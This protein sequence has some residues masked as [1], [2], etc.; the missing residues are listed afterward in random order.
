MKA[1]TTH[2]LRRASLAVVFGSL[3][4]VPSFG[5]DIKNIVQGPGIAVVQSSG[6]VTVSIPTGGITLTMLSSGTIAAVRG[7][8]GPAGSTGPQG[9]QGLTGAGGVTGTQ[10]L[11]GDIGPVGPIGAIGPV[12]PAGPTGFTGLQGPAGAEGP[13]GPIGPE[14][15]IGPTGLTGINGLDGPTGPTGATGPIGATGGLGA[16]GALGAFGPKGPFGPTGPTGQKG[17]AGVTGDAGPTGATGSTG[18]MGSAG[19]IGAAGAQ[20][21]SV[22]VERVFS[23]SDLTFSNVNMTFE[24][25]TVSFTSFTPVLIRVHAHQVL[26]SPV[27]GDLTVP[28]NNGLSGTLDGGSVSA[29]S[30]LQDLYTEQVLNPGTYDLRGIVNISAASIDVLSGG[31]F[32]EITVLPSS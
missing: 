5:Q 4:V 6:N 18:P 9:T 24:C 31:T 1:V 12:G 27:T 29:Y 3:L 25:P 7:P 32:V 17:A 26:T 30:T 14:G 21:P 2:S 23:G 10:G 15:N 16:V 11:V 8:I 20:G 19:A 22:L 28:L 13:I